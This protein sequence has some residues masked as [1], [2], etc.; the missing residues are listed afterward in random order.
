LFQGVLAK[1]T[2][3]GIE[4]RMIA[5]VIPPASS[6]RRSSAGPQLDMIKGGFH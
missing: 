3:D 6:Q 2:S 4:V 1:P 5:S